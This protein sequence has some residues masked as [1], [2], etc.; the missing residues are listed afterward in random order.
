[1]KTKEKDILLE[2]FYNGETSLEEE[3][4]IR[5]HILNTNHNKEPEAT[6]FK[7][8]NSLANEYNNERPQSIRTKKIRQR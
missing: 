7:T 1:M 6:L 5:N 4:L 8:Y 3:K 2:K